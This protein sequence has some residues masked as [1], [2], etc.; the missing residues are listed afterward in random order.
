MWAAGKNTTRAVSLPLLLVTVGHSYS[1]D[2]RGKEKLP[3]PDTES[4]VLREP[5]NGTSFK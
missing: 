2:R 5:T 3:E 1:H 4:A